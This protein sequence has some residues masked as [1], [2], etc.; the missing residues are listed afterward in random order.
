MGSMLLGKVV[1][2]DDETNSFRDFKHSLATAFIFLT[3]AD[4]YIGTVYPAYNAN[5]FNCNYFSLIRFVI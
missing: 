1:N 2:P 4:N 5:P 3:T